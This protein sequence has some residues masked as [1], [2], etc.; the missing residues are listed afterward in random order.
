MTGC[1]AV[2]IGSRTFVVAMPDEKEGGRARVRRRREWQVMLD[3]R[4]P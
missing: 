1:R 4:A 3:V 2:V